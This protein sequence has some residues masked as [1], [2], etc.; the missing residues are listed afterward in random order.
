MCCL[1]VGEHLVTFICACTYITHL[2]YLD[3]HILDILGHGSK[4]LDL[5]R[6]DPLGLDILGIIPSSCGQE[7]VRG[8][9][10]V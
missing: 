10:L 3:H 1:L 2:N 4:C 5:M 9:G 7:E 6:L 8:V